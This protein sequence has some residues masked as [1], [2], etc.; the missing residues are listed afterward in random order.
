MPAA[1]VPLLEIGLQKFEQESNIAVDAA[2]LVL[3]TLSF[4]QVSTAGSKN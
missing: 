3:M 1:I 2:K 4:A